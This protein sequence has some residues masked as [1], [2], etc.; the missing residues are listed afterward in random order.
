M[1]AARV[2]AKTGAGAAATTGATGAA[3]VL[4][5]YRVGDLVQIHSAFIGAIIEN[6]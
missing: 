3:T 6:V 1:G 2:L 5:K 4:A